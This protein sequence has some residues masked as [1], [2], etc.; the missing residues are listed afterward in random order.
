[1]TLIIGLG[2]GRCGTMSLAN[3]IN[4]QPSSVCFHELNPSCMSW[5]GSYGTVY[6]M[7]RDF[8]GIL[9]GGQRDHLTV[10]RTSSNNAHSI[11]RLTTIEK[12]TSLGDLGFYYLPY[13]ERIL[14]DFPDVRFP[15][16]KRD[17]EATVG[18]Y[19]KKMTV[20]WKRSSRD[21]FRMRPQVRNH[22]MVHDGVRW[23]FDRKWDK[24]YPK[25]EAESL[26]DAIGQYWDYYYQEATRLSEIDARVR[27]FDTDAMNNKE[28][29]IEI[30]AFCGITDAKFFEVHSNASG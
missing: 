19:I 20:G 5:A 11:E 17:R 3:L 18:S 8:E 14:R 2:T 6:S 7:L 24:C 15:C 16:L 30:L 4:S 13:V 21:F 28:S 25:F 22:F 9:G 10:D 26:E 1:M 12:V 27:I 29:Q 23:V